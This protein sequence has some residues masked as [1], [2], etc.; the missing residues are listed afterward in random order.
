MSRTPTMSRVK[1]TP[2]EGFTFPTLPF[3]SVF[4]AF[5]ETEKLWLFHPGWRPQHLSKHVDT[6]LIPQWGKKALTPTCHVPAFPVCLDSPEKEWLHCESMITSAN[7][8]GL[9]VLYWMCVVPVKLSI[10]IYRWPNGA[11]YSGKTQCKG[12][13]AVLMIG[14]WNIWD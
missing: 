9:A 12:T 3:P 7:P 6:Y 13:F 2:A 14:L 1:N 10:C 8:K 4:M 5:H 11:N